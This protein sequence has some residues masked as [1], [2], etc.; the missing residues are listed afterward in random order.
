M[1]KKL[2]IKQLLLLCFLIVSCRNTDTALHRFVNP[3]IGTGG[4]GH[5]Y[6]GAT[7]PFG[8]VQLSPDSRLEGWD[9]CSGYHY[10]DSIIYGFSHTHL[11]GTGVS[12]YGDLLLM[13]GTGKSSFDNKEYAS[14][15]SHKKE[16]AEAGYYS[17][18]LS[19]NN[20]EAELTTSAR[21]GMHRYRFPKKA[22]NPH[23]VIDLEHRDELLDVSLI[24]EGQNSLKGSRISKAWATNQHFYFVL[25][26]SKNI[27]K[28]EYKKW[29]KDST[30]N[31]KAIVYFEKGTEELI[32]RVGISFVDIEGA[33]KNLE[34]ELTHF[35][36]DKL[37]KLAQENWDKALGK[38]VVEGGTKDQKSIF[39]TA[40]YH[41]MIAPNIF[42]DSD[43]R[44]RGMDNKIHK[45]NEEDIYTIFSLWDT[46]RGAHPL[47]T[48]IE[49]KRTANFI[50]TF[51]AH[52]QQGG[53][54]P[55]WELAGN[56][57][58]CM[59]GYHSV[60][61][62]LD[63][64]KKGIKNFDANLALEA[65]QFSANRETGGLKA[66]K[67]KGF[68]EMS[69]N[70]ESVS[71]T[72]EYAYDDWCIAEMAK[73]LEKDSIYRHF[74]ARA[75]SYKNVFDPT[76]GFMRARI[77]GGFFSPFSPS[78][79]N[80]NYTEANSWQYSLFVPH[81]I[82]GLMQ[83]MG[84]KAGFEKY[85]DSLFTVSSSLGGHE[86]ADITGLIGQYA[87]G[88][89]PSH[90]K[91][92]LY[93]FVGKPWKTQKRVRQIMDELYKNAPDGL[94]GNEDCGQ[95]SAWYVLSAMGFYPVTPGT[96]NYVLG[97]A[98][99]DKVTINFEDGKSFVIESKGASSKNY[100][101]NSANLNGKNYSKSYISYSDMAAGGTLSLKM[102]SS[103]NEKWAV[104]DENC[105][106]TAIEKEMATL[107]VPYFNAPSN[108]FGE[109]LKISIHSPEKGAEIYY[110]MGEEEEISK[111]QLYEKP[112]TIVNTST[113]HTYCKDKKGRKSP[114]LKA[115]FPKTDPNRKIVLNAKFADR[116][117]GGGNNALIDEIFGGQ[118]YR[119]GFW[120]GYQE[121]LKFSVDLGEAKNISYVALNCLQDQRSWIWFPTNVTFELSTDGVN[122]TEV[123][124][125]KNDIPE[126]LSESITK[127]LG[128]RMRRSGRYIRVTAKNYGKCPA[129]HTGAGGAAWIFADELI[130]E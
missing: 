123:G 69:D 66:L 75:Q 27:S 108:A 29:E 48:L 60:S 97:T 122:F 114:I 105:P 46:F 59:I 43:G 72:L 5:T 35:D 83:L 36:F 95:M 2:K 117:A 127:K 9:G 124:Q 92:Y 90:H 74:T 37:K 102:Q 107:P 14:P 129:W 7:Q 15:F 86:Q 112:I 23:I 51:L 125:A 52:Y 38:I 111:A 81:D 57:T 128:V 103:P 110:W 50:K 45:T 109:S 33:G 1:S 25:N 101:I 93:N 54:L 34:K 19:K 30:K 31:S 62:I 100:H 41:T 96:E 106:K 88:N 4:H 116:Y 8:M 64:Y 115:Y 18:H 49:R 55:V 3:F 40:L 91:A 44:Y 47:Y 21:C 79:V 94:S 17:V 130:V 68:I 98:I 6:P 61:V 77:N 80:F 63:A 71:K 67:D 26:F 65:M 87:H 104:S 39:Y 85:L 24:Q 11:S 99:F 12:D 16:I 118:D 58:D 53:R 13:P 121:D 20:I 126:N 28:I 32:T 113:F 10:S 70:P 119:S 78:E 82:D 89:E 56:E 120:Q 42:N 84:G 22:E 76:T 73:A